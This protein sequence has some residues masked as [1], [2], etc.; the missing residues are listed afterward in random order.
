MKNTKSRLNVY[1]SRFCLDD[2]LLIF[3][4]TAFSWDITRFLVI[5]SLMEFDEWSFEFFANQAASVIPV[6]SC[7]RNNEVP[8][9]SASTP[10]RYPDR[11]FQAEQITEHLL[12][13]EHIQLPIINTLSS[14][15]P[16]RIKRNTGEAQMLFDQNR[17]LHRIPHSWWLL[18]Y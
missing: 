1:Y 14:H 15:A 8:A 4:D 3:V 16:G 6:E 12:V 18:W 11:H 10:Q 5:L 13:E 2:R 17:L 7:A 9:V